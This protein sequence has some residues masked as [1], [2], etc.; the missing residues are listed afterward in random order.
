[1]P[2]CSGGG[3]GVLRIFRAR[4]DRPSDESNIVYRSHRKPVS[5]RAHYNSRTSVS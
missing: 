5:R 4:R 3:A 2:R 1:M